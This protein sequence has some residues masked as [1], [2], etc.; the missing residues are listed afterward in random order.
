VIKRGRIMNADEKRCPDCAEIVKA[1]ARKCRFCGHAFTPPPSANT[2]AAV[3]AQ[4]AGRVLDLLS[5]LVEK[6]LVAYEA[7]EHGQ[8]RYQLLETVRQYGRDRLSE[9]GEAAAAAVRERHRDWFC[10]LAE[11]AAPHLASAERRVWLDRLE[12]EKE[13]LRTAA[14]AKGA[15]ND[16]SRETRWR[17]AGA[18]RWFWYFDGRLDE[19]RAWLEALLG[20]Q[21]DEADDDAWESAPG[22][23]ARALHAAGQL[24]YYQG[25]YDAARVWLT[26]SVALWRQTGNPLGLA[27]ALIHDGLARASRRDEHSAAARGVLYESVALL[28]AD[29]TDPWGLALALGY[30]GIVGFITNDD[31]DQTRATLTESQERFRALNDGWG[32]STPLWYLGLLD[33]RLNDLAAARAAFK[34][35]TV[36][37]RA[38]GDRWREASCAAYQGRLALTAG[39]INEAATWYA[40][41]L[42]LYHHLGRPNGLGI[43]LL[44][45]AAVALRRGGQAERAARLL[46]ASDVLRPLC[47]GQRQWNHAEDG[48]AECAQARNALGEE[49]FETAFAQGRTM[50][51]EQVLAHT[52]P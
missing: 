27:H 52:N 19:G 6:S 26:R 28:R 44:G 45:L 15:E 8:G 11:Q 4:D 42:R 1:A 33:E 35:V 12:R 29:G 5:A 24:A 14:A 38:A 32:E 46:G 48:E 31:E 17:L 43:A 40:A 2:D 21:G 18:L 37:V 49:A 34:R 7:E 41:A 25:D 9:S 22:Q 10:D 36:L 13:N 3:G 23:A 39:E 51:P 30:G 47:Q 50:T 20:G 16:A